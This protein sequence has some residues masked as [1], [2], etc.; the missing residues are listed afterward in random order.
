MHGTRGTGA[1]TWLCPDVGHE[2][3]FNAPADGLGYL[4][5]VTHNGSDYVLVGGAKTPS[6]QRIAIRRYRQTLR[7]WKWGE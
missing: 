5:V 3:C 6:A 2:D 7:S 1:Y 4:T